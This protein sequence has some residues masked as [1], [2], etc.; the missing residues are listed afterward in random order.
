MNQ[1][2]GRSYPRMPATRAHDE[3][4]LGDAEWLREAVRRFE[5]SLSD[6]TSLIEDN[7]HRVDEYQNLSPA[8]GGNLQ[9]Q[10]QPDYDVYPEIIEAVIVTG[11]TTGGV[12]FT[13]QLG[14][15]IW[16]LLMPAAGIIVIAPIKMSLDRDDLRQVSSATAGDWTLELMGYADIRYRYK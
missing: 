7:S 6:L 16:P 15:R 3:T 11:P 14:K 8:S 1:G 2:P 10:T 9:V 13:L 5:R 4:P 12:A